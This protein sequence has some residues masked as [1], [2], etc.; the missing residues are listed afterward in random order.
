VSAETAPDRLVQSGSGVD[1]IAGW[2]H[3]GW[4]DLVEQH[5]HF[6]R[7]GGATIDREDDEPRFKF[8]GHLYELAPEPL[9]RLRRRFAPGCN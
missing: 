7:A 1:Q 8:E 2:A 5:S 9:R 3:E 4:G 6:L